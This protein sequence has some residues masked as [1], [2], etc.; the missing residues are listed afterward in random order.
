MPLLNIAEAYP[1]VQI[2]YTY[3]MLQNDPNQSLLIIEISG[4]I[5]V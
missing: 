3:R 2:L 5:T 1:Y 4:K